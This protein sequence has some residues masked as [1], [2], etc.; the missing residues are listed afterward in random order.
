MSRLH[1]LLLLIFTASTIGC[2]QLL[3]PEYRLGAIHY[4]SKD[5]SARRAN[6]TITG[7]N[8]DTMWYMSSSAGPSRLY[9]WPM[10]ANYVLAS[11]GRIFRPVDV[12]TLVTP[13]AS[14]AMTNQQIVDTL[15]SL[16]AN[17]YM[18]SPWR[19]T[20]TNNGTSGLRVLNNGTTTGTGLYVQ[21]DAT[22]STGHALE[23]VSAGG[24]ALYGLAD[25]G[26]GLYARSLQGAAIRAYTGVT[27]QFEV[28]QAGILMDTVIVPGGIPGTA[29]QIL[30]L[31]GSATEMSW[32][33][34]VGGDIPIIDLS[35]ASYNVKGGTTG[36]LS[37]KRINAT[38]LLSAA[39]DT[40]RYLAGDSTWS[41]PL[42]DLKFKEESITGTIPDAIPD[43]A[44]R[45]FFTADHGAALTGSSDD[46]HFENVG[47]N[48]VQLQ[49][50][51]ASQSDYGIVTPNAQAIGGDKTMYGLTFL[52]GG[53][54]NDGL[55]ISGGATHPAGGGTLLDVSPGTILLPPM[56]TTGVSS[57]LYYTGKFYSS[58]GT[59]AADT[60]GAVVVTPTVA[61]EGI[62]NVKTLSLTR[63]GDYVYNTAI[64]VGTGG[65]HFLLG[66]K[67]HGEP[68]WTKSNARITTDAT[69][70]TILKIPHRSGTV[71]YNIHVMAKDTNSSTSGAAY[72]K[73]YVFGSTGVAI[74]SPVTIIE[75]ESDAAWDAYGTVVSGFFLVRIT[76]KAATVIT[77]QASV[78]ERWAENLNLR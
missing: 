66:G 21:S 65:G 69:E 45:I 9:P 52:T 39:S 11:N 75:A 72:E 5:T 24:T 33:T 31:N 27:K 55:G 25:T 49:I 41:R 19:I 35:Q 15:N 2:S 14:S 6:F 20:V 57:A 54:Y 7:I 23:A 4:A 78:E 32:Q 42:S 51:H 34:L 61:E 43:A 3:L 70:I 16:S 26:M 67:I 63:N 59:T 74:G 47:A 30:K 18:T 40:G 36:Q 28:G 8:A 71:K 73:V 10:T 64:N 56:A 13:A 44:N 48:N 12:N 22:T 76:G 1:K 60:G 17:E 29:S 58:G 68:I 37:V 46:I 50:N 77:W 38:G 62:N 53:Y